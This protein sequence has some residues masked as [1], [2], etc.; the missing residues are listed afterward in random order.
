M[1]PSIHPVDFDLILGLFLTFWGTNGLFWGLGLDSKTGLGFT[2]LVK[3]RLFHI[4]PSIL[5]LDFDLM[6][7]FFNAAYTT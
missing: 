1:F 6:G 4:F 7:H 5:T 2:H 3:Q